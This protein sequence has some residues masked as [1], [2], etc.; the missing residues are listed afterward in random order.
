MI[1]VDIFERVT[2]HLVCE[3]ICIIPKYKALGGR[4]ENIIKV[5][6]WV[7]L[8]EFLVSEKL[9]LRYLLRKTQLPLKC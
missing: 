1:F 5:I 7:V 9:L 4:E 2:T 3:K 6:L 8:Q